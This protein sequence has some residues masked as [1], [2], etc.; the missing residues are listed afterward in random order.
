MWVTEHCDSRED[1]L[2]ENHQKNAWAAFHLSVSAG[3]N[4]ILKHHAMQLLH[5]HGI[6]EAC[7]QITWVGVIDQHS[8]GADH[9]WQV[10]KVFPT[11]TTSDFILVAGAAEHHCHVDGRVEEE[12]PGLK[13]ERGGD[14]EEEKEEDDEERRPR[15][16]RRVSPGSGHIGSLLPGKEE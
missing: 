9:Y 6:T 16:G 8:H 12:R 13:G 10:D 7:Q 2:T 5:C 4:I 11:K 14:E 1:I 15:T 3:A